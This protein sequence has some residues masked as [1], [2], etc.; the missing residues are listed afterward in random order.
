[1]PNAHRTSCL[2]A[3][4]AGQIG[5]QVAAR[6]KQMNIS[7][8]VVERNRRVGDNWRKRYESL[9]LHTAK[10]QHQR[11]HHPSTWFLTLINDSFVPTSSGLLEPIQGFFEAADEVRLLRRRETGQLTHVVVSSRVPLR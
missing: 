3:V 11:K 7:C 2:R 6:F 1:M 5:V 4:G 10:E 9:A 8:I